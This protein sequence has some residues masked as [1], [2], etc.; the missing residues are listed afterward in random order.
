MAKHLD[1]ARAA[2]E[3]GDIDG[4]LEAAEQAAVLDPDDGRVVELLE[5]VRTTLEDRQIQGLLEQARERL[6]AGALTEAFRP[7]AEVRAIRSTDAGAR[8]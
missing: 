1:A 3:K 2:Q 5:Q 6:Q 7:L 4:A 8:R